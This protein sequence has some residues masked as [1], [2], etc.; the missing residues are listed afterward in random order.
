ML[1]NE[2]PPLGGG[3][4]TVNRAMLQYFA[5]V[6]C[7]EIDLVTSALGKRA[8]K[9]I[10]AERIIIHKVPVNNKNI[11][12]SSN[13][14]LSAYAVR[15]FFHALKLH[16]KRNY[17]LCFAWNAV[18]AGAI[19]LL[20][21][22]LTGLRYLVRV[23]G[24]DIPGF[25]RRYR[26][27]Y[28]VLC[29]LIRIIWR[30]AERVVAKS[31][32]ELEMI[33]ILDHKANVSLIHNGVDLSTFKPGDAVPDKGPLRLL[34]VGRLIERKGQHYLIDAVKRLTDEGIDVTLDL[35]GMGDAKAANQAQVEALGL[36]DRVRFLGY[37]P[38]EEIARYYAIAHVFVLPSYN[39]GMSVALLEAM[40]AGLP[41][42]V[43][44]TGGTE[45]LVDPGVNGLIFNWADS[46]TLA[47]QLRRLAT[48]RDLARKMGIASRIIAA[49]FSWGTAAARYIE[50]FWKLR[51]TQP[52]QQQSV[53]SWES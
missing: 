10:F 19:A 53:T 1:N 8:Q 40:A 3:T 16:R 32:V 18:P 13:R 41:V 20:L 4:G 9:E 24:P 6:Q 48:N 43:T 7:L 44:R 29:P 5:Q 38:R 14:E 21:Q 12:H 49:R 22:K 45:E 17:D 50:I 37:V 26:A 42:V 30:G 15:G 25:E 23:C 35:V 33:R 31:D 52:V 51:A 2:F 27:V 28:A 34:C 36:Q 47:H 11:H 39:E 46:D